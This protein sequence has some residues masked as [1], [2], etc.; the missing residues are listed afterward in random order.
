MTSRRI[1]G[2]DKRL[3]VPFADGIVFPDPVGAAV[4]AAGAGGDRLLLRRG[5]V[6]MLEAGIGERKPLHP[7][8]AR[9]ADAAEIGEGLGRISAGVEPAPED[10]GI[11]EG[12]AGALSG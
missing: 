5:V 8:H 1:G 4:D 11:L 9:D 12:L 3:L 6:H 2:G 7:M 10:I